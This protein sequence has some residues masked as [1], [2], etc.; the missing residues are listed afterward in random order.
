MSDL[1]TRVVEW[2]TQPVGLDIQLGALLLDWVVPCKVQFDQDGPDVHLPA[3]QIDLVGPDVLLPMVLPGLI[4][5]GVHPPM[6]RPVHI[7]F[8]VLH[9]Y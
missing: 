2:G 5:F 1:G 8:V 9:V 7:G 4:D 3:A 6:F